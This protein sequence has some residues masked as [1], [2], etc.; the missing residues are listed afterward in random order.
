MDGCLEDGSSRSRCECLY[1]YI[2]TR[3]SHDEF[4]GVGSDPEDWPARV[5]RVTGDAAVAC[6]GGQPAEPDPSAETAMSAPRNRPT[7]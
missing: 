4:T 1:E 7:S 2:S 3:L 5:R 6:D